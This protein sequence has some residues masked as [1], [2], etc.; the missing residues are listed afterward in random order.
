MYFKNL[1]K[2]IQSVDNQEF[3]TNIHSC[4]TGFSSLGNIGLLQSLASFLAFELDNICYLEVGVF[5]GMTLL[6]TAKAAPNLPCYGIDNFNF[7]DPNGQNQSL[8]E[9]RKSEMQLNNTELINADYEDALQSLSSYIGTK[10]IG[11][12]LIDGPHDYR[13][14]LMCLQMALPYL[15]EKAVIIIDDCN[16]EHVRQA[17]ADFL[18]T[19]PEFKLLFQS[20]S[21]CHPENVSGNQDFW[22]DGINVI[23]K[24]VDDIL[25]KKSNSSK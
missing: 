17:N 25:P 12:Y 20:Y 13:S 22:W 6:S 2:L 23:V 19:H 3:K 14:Q 7:F 24:D 21:N 10:K 18:L 9:S 16:Y 11:L 15:H 5:Q 4:L 8:I 1:L